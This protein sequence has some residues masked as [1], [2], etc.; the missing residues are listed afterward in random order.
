MCL[1]REKTHKESQKKKQEQ[2]EGDKSD[3]SRR[4]DLYH[5]PTPPPESPLPSSVLN[6]V[7]PGFSPFLAG[8]EAGLLTVHPQCSSLGAMEAS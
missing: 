5:P 4:R 1:Q 3:I 6:L 2:V 8:V 7:L